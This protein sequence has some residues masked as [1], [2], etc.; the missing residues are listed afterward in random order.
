[1]GIE[2]VKNDGNV[3]SDFKIGESFEAYAKRMNSMFP[4]RTTTIEQKKTA[5]IAKNSIMN[6][7]GCPSEVKIT[8]QKEIA[9]IEQEIK[10]IER[11][12]SMNKSV[13]GY[14]KEQA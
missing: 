11:E 5:I 13:F 14:K 9:I 3:S 1:M 2:D 8:L 12:Q 4:D 10:S 6:H 7:P